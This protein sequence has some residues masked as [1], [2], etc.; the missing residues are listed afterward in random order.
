MSEEWS[1]VL[2][3]TNYEVSRSGIVRNKKTSRPLKQQINPSGYLVVCLHGSSKGRTFPIH[4]LI[5][6]C[7]VGGEA[8]GLEV[9]HKDGNPLNNAPN[10]LEW[11]THS[12]NMH[13]RFH[14][15]GKT[16]KLTEEIVR[17]LVRF[18]YETGASARKVGK[19]YGIDA[20][21]VSA[22]L[23]GK[24]WG[25]LWATGKPDFSDVLPLLRRRITIRDFDFGETIRTLD[26][27][28]TNRVDCYRVFAD[29]VEWKERAGW[30]K[31][32]AGLRKS[33]PRVGAA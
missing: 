29:G 30:S 9:N 14:V 25:H 24:S 3:A 27:Y 19:K 23:S 11:V 28:R 13:H 18:K 22:I 6:E 20:S 17:E 2:H 4:R 31:I 26:L 33:M 21:M 10:N 32:L 1:A 8:N 15:L 5:A 7:F 16:H 12:E